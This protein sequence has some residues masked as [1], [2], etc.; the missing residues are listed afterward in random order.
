[1]AELAEL[2]AGQRWRIKDWHADDQAQAI[3]LLIEDGPRGPIVHVGVQGLNIAIPGYPD[4]IKTVGHMPFDGPAAAAGLTELI[5][6]AAPLPDFRSGYDEWRAA[7]ER[8]EAGVYTLSVADA[9]RTIETA[10]RSAPPPPP[11]RQ[12]KSN[13]G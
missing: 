4:G 10:L 11:I 3:I 6:E 7:F 12:M 2:R 9:I 1:M 8:G 5:S 13:K